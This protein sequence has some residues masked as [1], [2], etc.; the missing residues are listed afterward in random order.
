MDA[1]GLR[2]SQPLALGFRLVC[3]F[4]IGWLVHQSQL[5]SD[6]AGRRPVRLS[7]VKVFL[8]EAH[9]LRLN[10]GPAGGLR[11]LDQQGEQIG[12]ATKTMPHS[13]SVKGYSGPSDMLLVYDAEEQLLGIAFRHSYDTSSH[14]DDVA[15]DYLFME[16]WNGKTRQQIA[17]L[18]MRDISAHHIVSGASRT[19]EAVLQSVHLR[20][21]M[22]G[23]AAS[24]PQMRIRWQDV[25]LLVCVVLALLLTFTKVPWLNRRKAWVQA[26]IAIYIGLISGDL[27]AQSLIVS[28]AQHG[29]PWY[30]VLGLVLLLAAALIIPWSTGKPIYCTHLCPHGHAQRFLMKITPSRWRPKLGQPEKW[31]FGLLPGLTLATILVI[32]FWRLPIDLAGMEPFDAW[33]IKGVGMAT[34]VIAVVGLIFSIFVPM[35]Y[36]RYGCPTGFLLDLVRRDRKGFRSRDWWLLAL[37]ALSV[38]LYWLPYPFG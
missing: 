29:V 34:V 11:V 15:R 33:A 5:R 38:A 1:K 2:H 13:R 32:T 18:E 19:S 25:A 23:E 9:Q 30:S 7:E 21:A 35:G 12:L 16:Q 27:L 17:A 10:S 22:G 37:L 31:S 4:A 36:C 3:L 28:W 6:Q 26:A 14:V 24:R 20:A 8:P